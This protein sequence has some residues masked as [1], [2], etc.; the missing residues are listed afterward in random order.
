MLYFLVLCLVNVE[1]FETEEPRN[2][3]I[4]LKELEEL[5]T[6][7]VDINSARM[8][9]FMKIPYLTMIDC[10]KIIGYRNKCG[11][12]N[13]VQELLKI[14]GFDQALFAKI[15]PYITI[16]A[17]TIKFE[18]ASLRAR[19]EKTLSENNSE[20]YYTNLKTVVSGYSLFLVTEK[21]PYETN[22]FDY[23]SAGMVLK[24]DKR[25]FAF[26]RYD[27]D[28]GSGMTISS[29][30]SLFESIDFRT[31]AN[32][33]GIIPHTAAIENGGFFGAAI[34]DSLF[35][36]YTLFYSNQRLDGR[37]DSS[38]YARSFDESGEHT[39][40]LELSRKDRINEEIIGYDIKYGISNILLSNR[41][42]LCNYSPSFICDDSS[43]QF[44]G[45]DF[46]ISAV[47]IKYL[48]E[49]FI[50]FTEMAR[51]FKGYVG[52][53]IGFS[54]I[55]PFIDFN[56]AGSY[57]SPGFYSPKGVESKN[58]YIGLSLDI[59]NHSKIANLDATLNVVNR[60][61]EDS[62]QYDLR[63]NF[64][65]GLKF[66]NTRFQMR[67]RFIENR[68]A[69]SGSRVFLHFT[70]F[71]IVYGDLRLEERYI[72][73]DTLEKGIFGGIELGFEFKKIEMK[74]RYGL[75]STDSYAS[76][77]YAYEPDLPGIIN[78]RMLF[79]KGNYG[80]LYLSLRPIEKISI[81]FK[82]SIFKK[83]FCIKHLG[84]QLDIR[85]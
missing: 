76:R 23:Y 37:I 84:A 59:G 5:K 50:L 39:D 56:L 14:P 74:F 28:L 57:Y 43:K 62:S 44:Y 25:R 2:F 21:D 12:F 54:S 65:K 73:S 66:L 83:N 79:N 75:F 78:N 19:M 13:A 36:N 17:R 18:K 20:E 71:K 31:S 82:Y 81:S 8:E 3:E 11:L 70:P 80:F 22:F 48:G 4:I 6:N 61:E 67:W 63:L 49:T 53:L 55:F 27:L 30:G 16:K 15:E 29:I 24:D 40:S 68:R 33:R 38:G 45:K 41:S 52:G 35:L 72:Y 26:G 58:D 34:S 46:W 85:W 1:I 42:Y 51:G 60:T 9:D 32:E 77:I 47:S 7:P 10:L 64:E 69:L